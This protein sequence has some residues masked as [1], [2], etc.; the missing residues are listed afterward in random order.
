MTEDSAR[1]GYSGAAASVEPHAIAKSR[2]FQRFRFEEAK[3][4]RNAKRN[5]HSLAES[6]LVF[7]YMTHSREGLPLNRNKMVVCM[8]TGES[9]L[10]VAYQN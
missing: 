4:I 1:I 10:D 7:V 6:P 2:F 8:C 3:E 5:K 9:F